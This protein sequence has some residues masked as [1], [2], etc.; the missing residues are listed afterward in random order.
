MNFYF[1]FIVNGGGLFET[2]CVIKI[3]VQGFLCYSFSSGLMYK[4]L[5]IPGFLP[6][7]IIMFN[8]IHIMLICFIE[9]KW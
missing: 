9:I 4:S 6:K 1:F 2:S 7:K 5:Q 3:N 8:I